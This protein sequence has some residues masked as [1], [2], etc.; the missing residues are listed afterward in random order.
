MIMGKRG[1]II[2]IT[3]AFFLLSGRSEAQIYLNNASF[4]GQPQDATVPVGW[5]PCEAGTTPDIL[6]GPWG[7]FTEPSEGQ[8]FVGLITREDG[9]WESICQRLPESIKAS[10]CH[11]FELD[12]ARSGSYAGYNDPIRLRIWGGMRKCGK[13]QLLFTSQLIDHTD[14]ETY[15]VSFTAKQ[16]INYILIEACF[17]DRSV[18]QRGNVLIDNITAI[19]KCVRA[20]MD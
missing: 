18:S 8:T 2:F 3:I 19:R 10:D 16:P 7:V 17:P 20:M 13:D 1:K 9:S 5:L 4:E 11:E 12:L 15:K 14:W 6:P